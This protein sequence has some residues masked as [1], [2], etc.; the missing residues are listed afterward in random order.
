MVHPADHHHSAELRGELSRQVHLN[1]T[2][3]QAPMK[4]CVDVGGTKIAVSLSDGKSA[5]LE[6]LPA[7]QARRSEFTAKSGERDAVALQILRML[8]EACD[9][10][11]ISER[12]I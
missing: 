7:L 6:G 10:A 2:S 1:A 12:D 9:E 8:G 11:A 4:A 5:S 3:G